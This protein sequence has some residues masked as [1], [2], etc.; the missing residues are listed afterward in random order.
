MSQCHSKTVLH[1][2]EEDCDSEEVQAFLGAID[3]NTQGWC[4]TVQISEQPVRVKI[5]TGAD[6]TAIPES[7]FTLLTRN[8]NTSHRNTRKTLMGLG[9]H[10]LDVKA[11]FSAKNE[12]I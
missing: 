11:I 12:K 8:K 5:D 6:V 4:T 2:V 3:T 7:V 9:R 10:V 1:E